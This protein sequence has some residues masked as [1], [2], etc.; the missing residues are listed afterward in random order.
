MRPILVIDSGIGG[1]P[2]LS[3]VRDHLPLEHLIYVAD[4]LN[5]PY[6][7][8]SPAEVATRV[9]DL[10][11]HLR[12]RFDPKLLVVACNTASV[13]ALRGLRERLDLP[14]VGVVP[15]VKTAAAVTRNDRI[16]ILATELTVRSAYLQDLIRSFAVERHVISLAA[17]DIVRFVEEDFFQ[18]TAAERLRMMRIWCERLLELGVDTLVLGCTHFLHVTDELAG[19]LG[20]GVRIVDSR[21]GVGRRIHFLLHTGGLEEREGPGGGIFF[22]HWTREAELP[23]RESDKYRL[24]A[25]RF[26]L[27][28][29]GLLYRENRG[30][31]G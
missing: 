28:Y 13:Y 30:S 10:A 19:F 20:E 15:A 27:E 9:V 23:A 14:V 26:G 21:D 16:G 24:F 11:L 4:R 6:G 31:D 1:L 17:G 8:K 3:W 12:E 18:P 5:F 2:Y 29:G 22:V 7:E 25:E